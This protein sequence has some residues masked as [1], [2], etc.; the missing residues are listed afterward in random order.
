[1]ESWSAPPLR[2]TTN[3]W[4]FTGGQSCTRN[5]C[6][7]TSQDHFCAGIKQPIFSSAAEA[8]SRKPM[9]DILL[10]ISRAYA[11]S[12]KPE[13]DGDVTRDSLKKILRERMEAKAEGRAASG[14]VYI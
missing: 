10:E 2:V 1:M 8:M 11:R 9:R 6:V 12:I 5:S 4:R 13:D 7:E 14:P 3:G